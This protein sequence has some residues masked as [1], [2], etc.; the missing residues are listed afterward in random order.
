LRVPHWGHRT[1]F[2]DA[3]TTATGA[4]LTTWAAKTHPHFRQVKAW[5]SMRM[6]YCSLFPVT[7]CGGGIYFSPWRFAAGQKPYAAKTRKATTRHRTGPIPPP[8]AQPLV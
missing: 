5:A 3:A 4:W 7:E 2:N 8:T 6:A 1:A